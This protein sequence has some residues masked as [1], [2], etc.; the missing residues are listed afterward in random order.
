MR[1]EVP[2]SERGISTR[3]LE[4]KRSSL[5]AVR[6][7]VTARYLTDC[8]SVRV[9]DEVT[10]S[11]SRRSMLTAIVSHAKRLAAVLAAVALTACSSSY[12][13]LEKAFPATGESGAPALETK[14]ITITSQNRRGAETYEGLVTIRLL[15]SGMELRNAAPFSDA[16]KIPMAEIAGCSMTCFGTSDQHVDVLVPKTGSDIMIPRS[17]A[18]LEWC[19]TN[20]KP[21]F[22]S[23]SQREWMYKGI[24]LPKVE[25]MGAQPGSR[26]EYDEQTKQSCL[27]F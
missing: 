15:D 21:M 13:D 12:S 5:V 4:H 14:T 22:S 19:W 27:G 8:W 11:N 24:P 6:A 20:R 26:A 23:K 1:G 17:D 9:E 18:L 10:R 3:V 7:R 16:V 2:S 25:A